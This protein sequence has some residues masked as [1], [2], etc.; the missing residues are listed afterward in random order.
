[1]VASRWY[2][3][4]VKAA[5]LPKAIN[6]SVSTTNEESKATKKTF[7]KFFDNKFAVVSLGQKGS[8]GMD[9]DLAIKVDLKDIDV[10]TM[11]FMSY[12]NVTNKFVVIKNPKYFIDKNGYLHFTTPIG[13]DIIITNGSLKSK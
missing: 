5:A 2:I 1:S 7:E 8:Y 10:K 9:M 6:L 11:S 13:G 4:P 12:D 3:D